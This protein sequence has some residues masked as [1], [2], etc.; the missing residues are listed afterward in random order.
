MEGFLVCTACGQ[1]FAEFQKSGL[2][3]CPACY[4]AFEGELGRIFKRL[5]GV[6]QH[7]VETPP[8]RDALTDLEAQLRDA[9]RREAYEEAV[10]LRD[11]IRG[12]KMQDSDSP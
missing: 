10:A 4:H 1:T 6:S 8:Q 9:V 2:M 7:R 11:Q 12:L 3:G 5:H